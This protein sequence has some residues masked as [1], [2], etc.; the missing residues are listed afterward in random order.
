MNSGAHFKTDKPVES[1]N[2]LY[3]GQFLSNKFTQQ[4]ADT[5]KEANVPYR[6][7]MNQSIKGHGLNRSRNKGRQYDSNDSSNCE[8]AT[9]SI[10]SDKLRE[11][12]STLNTRQD[13]AKKYAKNYKNMEK[14]LNQKKLKQKAEIKDR[15]IAE[16]R[17][18]RGYHIPHDKRKIN[19]QLLGNII[20]NNI[21]ELTSNNLAP[22][23]KSRIHKNS[24]PSG[25]FLKSIKSK[26]MSLK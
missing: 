24:K 9:S 23:G 2:Q 4:K 18:T 17:D 8:L 10:L 3:R 1:R 14:E 19:N 15:V 12:L 21:N 20:K 5:R 6:R 22:S 13:A 26:L 11:S 16:N 7:N 25:K